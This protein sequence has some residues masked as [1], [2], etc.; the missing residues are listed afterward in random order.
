MAVPVL[1]V[2]REDSEAGSALEA[3]NIETVERR[4]AMVGVPKWKLWIDAWSSPDV[5]I[6]PVT[7]NALRGDG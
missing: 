5:E 2:R 6:R 3:G 7:T 4:T 1:V